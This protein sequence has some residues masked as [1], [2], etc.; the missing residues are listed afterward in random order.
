MDTSDVEGLKRCN[1]SRPAADSC[2]LLSLPLLSWRLTLFRNAQGAKCHNIPVTF[3]M[4]HFPLDLDGSPCRV[5]YLSPPGVD[6]HS[7]GGATLDWKPSLLRPPKVPLA[8]KLFLVVVVVEYKVGMVTGTRLLWSLIL[9]SFR[10]HVPVTFSQSPANTH[11]HTHGH[12]TPQVITDS[13]STDINLKTL[14]MYKSILSIW[15]MCW[16]DKPLSKCNQ[17]MWE[18]NTPGLELCKVQMWTEP[19]K[20]KWARVKSEK[21]KAVFHKNGSDSLFLR[22]RC[23]C[24]LTMNQQELP[25]REVLAEGVWLLPWRCRLHT[26]DSDAAGA[27]K[28]SG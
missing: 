8:Q 19:K 27:G 24:D 7:T 10:G 20:D 9:G 12:T 25:T 13:G 4:F 14:Q 17:T 21:E 15:S 23:L 5:L 26:D 2:S 18:W 16:Y 3:S 22:K 28:N 6:C 11:G 1:V